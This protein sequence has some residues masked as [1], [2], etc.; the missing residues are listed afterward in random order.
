MYM[1]AAGKPYVHFCC[2]GWGGLGWGNNVQLHL[3]TM[4]TTR[5]SLALGV[6]RGGAFSCTCTL[7]WCYAVR[8]SLPSA[9]TPDAIMWQY[10]T[11]W[12]WRW[13]HHT[14]AN[15]SP[16]TAETLRAMWRCKRAEDCRWFLKQVR[17]RRSFPM[18]KCK[19]IP[20]T[21]H[22]AEAWFGTWM[23]KRRGGQNRTTWTKKNIPM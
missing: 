2:F 17:L 12:Q 23:F 13:E 1:L 14:V 4:M 3:H 11:Q 10:A 16:V 19:T 9:I 15:L 5:S 21:L 6:G 22:R 20:K 7:W 18:G 8:S